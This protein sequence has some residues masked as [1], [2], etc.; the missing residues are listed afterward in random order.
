MVQMA[1]VLR[2]NKTITTAR[3]LYK[4]LLRECKKLPA[5]AGEFYKHSIKQSYKQHILET[6]PQRIKQI[7]ER[8]LEDASWV[9]KKYAGQISK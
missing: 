1:N 6:D 4:Y 8:A 9:M 3:S 5:D 7:I 2:N